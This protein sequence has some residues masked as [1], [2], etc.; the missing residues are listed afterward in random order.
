VPI[1]YGGSWGLS[2]KEI[3]KAFKEQIASNKN[4][5]WA[6]IKETPVHFKNQRI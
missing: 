6:E 3:F 5:S 2:W 1:F 4:I